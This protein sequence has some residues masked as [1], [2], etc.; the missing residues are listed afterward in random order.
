MVT[1]LAI[2]VAT[3]SDMIKYLHHHKDVFMIRQQS[4]D[5]YGTMNF[6]ALERKELEELMFKY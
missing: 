1:N 3:E 5:W 6:N 4:Y 2:K